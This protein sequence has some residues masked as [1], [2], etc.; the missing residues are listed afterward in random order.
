MSIKVSLI[1]PCLNS[2][3]T[4]RGTI[5]SVLKQTYENIEYIIV[6][7]VSTD[8]TISTIEEY[9]PLFHGRMRY[10]SEKDNGIYDAM[11]KGIKQASGDVIG[12]IN[13]DDW[14]ESDAVEQA[15]RCFEDTDAD[16]VYGEMWIIDENGNREYHTFHSLFPLHPSTFV[17]RRAYQMYGIYNINY[18]IA[19]D[20]DL[21]LRFMTRQVQFEHIDAILANFRTSGISSTKNLECARETYEI[22][23][24]YLGKCPGNFLNVKDIEESYDRAKLLHISHVNPQVL[25]ETLNEKYNISEGVII[26]GV[27]NCGKELEAILRVCNVTILFFV[28]NDEKKWGLE[29]DGVKICSPEILRYCKGHVIITMTR[30]QK[31]ICDQIR[32]YSNQRLTWNTLEEVR[33]SIISKFE[34]M[35]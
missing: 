31:D 27:G 32:D 17:K 2:E 9:M 20:R 10:V 16:V 23:L 34:Y 14:Y 11:N 8:G 30:Y 22:N 13:S 19:A 1:T 33:K 18:R 24:K 21:L 7:G 35:F 4:I 28:D 29:K 15:V 5:E 26:F 25:K 12:I 3:K 6:D